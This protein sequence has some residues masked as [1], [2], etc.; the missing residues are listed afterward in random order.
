MLHPSVKYLPVCVFHCALLSADLF[1]S[2]SYNPSAIE[3]VAVN[4]KGCVALCVVSC[5]ILSREQAVGGFIADQRSFSARGGLF[6]S[7]FVPLAQSSR[8]EESK[9]PRAVTRSM[10]T[11]PRGAR[12]QPFKKIP[13]THHQFLLALSTSNITTMSKN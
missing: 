7:C 9:S 3:A 6:R 2:H 10:L 12:L 1:Q 11:T 4:G 13:P 8:G 5:V